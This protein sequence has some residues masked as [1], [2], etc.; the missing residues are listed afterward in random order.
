MVVILYGDANHVGNMFNM[1]FRG[2][3]IIYVDNVPIIWFGK[4][5]NAVESSRFVSEP[6]DLRIAMEMVEALRHKL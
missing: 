1:R 6:F 4:Q 5:K 2:S 3:I